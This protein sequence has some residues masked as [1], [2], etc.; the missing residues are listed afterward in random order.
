MKLNPLITAFSIVAI[1]A[2]TPILAQETNLIHIPASQ[3]PE[4]PMAEWEVPMRDASSPQRPRI[5]SAEGTEAVAR[6]P[7]YATRY[8]AKEY[9]FPM[10]SLRVLY[11]KEAAGPVVHQITFETQLMMLEGSATVGSAGKT[12]SI[13]KG[14]AVFLP[15]GVLRNDKPVGDTVVAT[16]I[17]SSTSENPKSMAV[18]GDDLEVR[19]IAQ[20]MEGDEAK[21]AFTQTDIANAPDYASRFDFRRYAFDGNSIRHAILQK[22]GQTTPATNSRTD[23]LIYILKGR[24]LRTEDGVEYNVAAGDAIREEYQKSGW[25]DL[26]EES[27]FLA[28]DMPFD[29]SKPR[30]N[31]QRSQDAQVGGGYPQ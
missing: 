4:I 9:N 2:T 28:T 23:I 11:F 19:S 14:D 17:V 5:G 24:M 8:M 12:I 20:W 13:K 27:E 22:G 1:L 3:A 21:G 29:P 26:L 6:A 31:V 10:G 25:W 30:F 7:D 16:W 18:N 15:S